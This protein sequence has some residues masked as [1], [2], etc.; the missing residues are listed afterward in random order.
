VGGNPTFKSLARTGVRRGG[1]GFKWK[2]AKKKKLAKNLL[3][4]IVSGPVGAFISSSHSGW[5]LHRDWLAR[6][7]LSQALERDTLN[8]GRVGM[9]GMVGVP[10]ALHVLL[11]LTPPHVKFCISCLNIV[12]S[13]SACLSAGLVVTGGN[14]RIAEAWG[15]MGLS[16]DIMG[17]LH[18]GSGTPPGV[19]GSPTPRFA[20]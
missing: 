5:C 10:E 17:C 7:G 20:D 9:V 18:S 8:L 2:G 15:L 12:A 4:L 11:T 19:P 13:T 14:R 16:G 6:L 3:S 1:P